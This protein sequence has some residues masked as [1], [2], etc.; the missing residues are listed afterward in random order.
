MSFQ[1]FYRQWKQYGCF[2]IHQVLSWGPEFQR[3]NL[4]RWIQKGYIRKLRK[5]WYVFAE[6]LEVPGVQY[7]IANKI[8]APSYISLQSALS[9]YGIIPET[10]IDV[11]SVNTRDKKS[12]STPLGECSYQKIRSDLFFGFRRMNFD[13]LGTILFA[14]PE[15]AILDFLYLNPWYQTPQDM[16][17]LRFDQDFMEDD[18]DGDKLM[19]MC[20]RFQ[21]KSLE[22]RI[23][24]L[25]KI[26]S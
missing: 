14:T 5:E 18:L 17:D 12:F 11:T 2:N 13:Q 10:V 8:Y 3:S 19:E 15:K 23:E 20:G 26:Y 24:T 1:E 21:N 22:K 16:E 25:L 7:L 4:T 6:T 9:F